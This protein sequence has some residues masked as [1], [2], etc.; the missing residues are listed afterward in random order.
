MDNGKLDLAFGGKATS[1]IVD[2]V[3]EDATRKEAAK[4]HNQAVDN[5]KR[6]LDSK[7]KKGL[8]E[9][10]AATK[11]METLEIVCL[12]YTSPSPRDRG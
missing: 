7:V 11:R 4:M 12:L 10:E 6:V 9:A 2:Q 5:Y 3:G 8:K 1:M